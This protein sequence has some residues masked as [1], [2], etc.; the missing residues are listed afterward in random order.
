MKNSTCL[1][2]VFAASSVAV[3]ADDRGAF[4]EWVGHKLPAAQKRLKQTDSRSFIEN[5]VGDM[6][7]STGGPA[8]SFKLHS[9]HKASGDYTL[10]G[11]YATDIR[12][13]G[14]KPPIVDPIC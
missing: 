5:G 12:P 13:A 10:L 14:V 11:S 8:V 3:R 9:L 4:D 1:L 2:L 6:E 7:M